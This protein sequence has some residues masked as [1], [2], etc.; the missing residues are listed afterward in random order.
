VRPMS[1]PLETHLKNRLRATYVQS[2]VSEVGNKDG[3]F[4]PRT[5]PAN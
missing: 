4:R 2:A 5:R 1:D 3:N